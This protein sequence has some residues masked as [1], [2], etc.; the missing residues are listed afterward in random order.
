MKEHTTLFEAPP[1]KKQLWQLLIEN[2]CKDWN[3]KDKVGLRMVLNTYSADG[4]S[5][6]LCVQDDSTVGIAYFRFG[7]Q[8]SKGF[9]KLMKLDIKV[10]YTN[11]LKTNIKN[12]C[13]QYI[14]QNKYQFDLL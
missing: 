8:A 5:F 6:H 12:V 1:T 10:R 3:W 11:G 2:L 9:M 14:L 13:K 4:I 7:S